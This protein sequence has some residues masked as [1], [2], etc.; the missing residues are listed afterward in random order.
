MAENV[1]PRSM[2]SRSEVMRSA[3][4]ARRSR[5]AIDHDLFRTEQATGA[6]EAALEDLMDRVLDRGVRGLHCLDRLLHLAVELLGRLHRGDVAS[7]EELEEFVDQVLEAIGDGL[8]CQILLHETLLEPVEAVVEEEEI[9]EQRLLG[10]EDEVF[11]V[12]LELLVELIE[13]PLL[14]G[15]VPALLLHRRAEALQLCEQGLCI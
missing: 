11:L 8:R 9:E 4:R 10:L 7:V 12:L 14:R 13:R 5:Q 2:P 3:V 15:L 6:E 1:V